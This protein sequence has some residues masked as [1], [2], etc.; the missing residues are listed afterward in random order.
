MKLPC[1]AFVLVTDICDRF[2]EAIKPKRKL[3]EL[4][5][6][7]KIPI[8]WNPRTKGPRATTRTPLAETPTA[9][10]TAAARA[11]KNGKFP[12]TPRYGSR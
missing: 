5:N 8:I 6:G 7:M 10:P 4:D 11:L 9:L 12:D 2:V 3:V 1:Y